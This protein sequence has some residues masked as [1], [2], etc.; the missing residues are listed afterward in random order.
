MVVCVASTFDG[1]SALDAW[2]TQGA[3]PSKILATHTTNGTVDRSRP[4][5]PYPQIARWKGVDSSDD[6]SAFE[7]IA[8]R[9]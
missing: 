7:C 2:V 5:C 1:L 8:P 9:R 4:L 6:A 3:A